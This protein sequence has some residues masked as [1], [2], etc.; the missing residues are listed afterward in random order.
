MMNYTFVIA[1]VILD[2]T[3][4]KWQKNYLVSGATAKLGAGVDNGLGGSAPHQC[5]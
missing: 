1:K 4:P 2:K 3:P 5:R